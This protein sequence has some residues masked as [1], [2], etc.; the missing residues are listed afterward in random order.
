M[1]ECPECRNLIRRLVAGDL[2]PSESEALR[3][4]AHVCDDCRRILEIHEELAGD[5]SRVP[6]PTEADF[7]IM[8]MNV[9]ARLGRGVG[10]PWWRRF[11]EDTRAYLRAQPAVAA[12]VLLLMLGGAALTGRWTARPSR[13]DDRMLLRT[14]HEQAAASAGVSGY[15]DAPFAYSNVSA[16]PLPRGR[17]A[18]SFDVCR[19]VELVAPEA[20]DLAKD[21][22]MH[23]IL[24]PAPVGTRLKAMGLTG[25]ITDARLKETVIFALHHDPDLAIRLKAF[26]VLSQYPYDITVQDALLT[27]LKQDESVQVRFQA[28]DYLAA[29]HVSPE[30]LR[31][32]IGEG[33]LESN[34][35]V[36][37]RALQLAAG[38]AAQPGPGL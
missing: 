14:I 23:A 36:M 30:T 3:K 31:R 28:L 18:L 5:G 9:L 8:R 10:R 20:S 26:E 38:P 27:T 15:W 6:E 17:L 2:T 1:K 7:R 33:S 24:E 29:R 35:A 19:H 4:H 37:Q 32:T 13:I 16:R 12:L 34:P 11:S 25:Q 21:V 22:L